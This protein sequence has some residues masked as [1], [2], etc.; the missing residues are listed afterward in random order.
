MT[1]CKRYRS[2]MESIDTQATKD[3]WNWGGAV[4]NTVVFEEAVWYKHW[5]HRPR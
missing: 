2:A 5:S 4:R 3:S 1:P